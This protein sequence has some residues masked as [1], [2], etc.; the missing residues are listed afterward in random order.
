M[1]QVAVILTV[2][3]VF[4]GG[5][6]LVERTS[7]PFFQQCISEA[8][9]N[10]GE[11]ATKE[12]DSRVG[13][14]IVVYVRCSGRFIDG[15]GGG[16]TALFTIVLAFS[17]VLLWIVTNKAAD[18][19][20]TA[21]EHIPSVERAYLFVTVKSENFGVVLTEYVNSTD[22]NLKERISKSRSGKMRFISS[23]LAW[24]VV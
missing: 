22:D 5:F 1:R 9:G 13:S 16:L 6:L 21:A 3:F 23:G 7:S 10:K 17:T 4:V 24:S 2:L 14:V 18:A 20:K 12:G 19:A 15:H 11:Q 8:S